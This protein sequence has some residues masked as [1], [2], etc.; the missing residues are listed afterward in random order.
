MRRVCE[1]ALSEEV[2]RSRENPLKPRA[3][4]SVYSAQYFWA[5]LL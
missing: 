1:I 5:A 4:G 2:V 3:G